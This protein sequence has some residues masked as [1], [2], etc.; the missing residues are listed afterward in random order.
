MEE[1]VRLLP[2]PSPLPGGYYNRFTGSTDWSASQT[3]PYGLLPT[4]RHVVFPGKYTPSG[5]ESRQFITNI[6]I[7]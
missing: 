1:L 7:A 6:I 5:T 4:R 3:I 2:K